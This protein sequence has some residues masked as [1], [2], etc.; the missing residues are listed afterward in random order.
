M[1]PA[2][3]C[4]A[5]RQLFGLSYCKAGQLQ[6]PCSRFK[7]DREPC[8]TNPRADT[9]Y[10]LFLAPSHKKERLR[11]LRSGGTLQLVRL[12]SPN[13]QTKPYPSCACAG[14]KIQLEEPLNL[15]T[16]QPAVVGVAI[17]RGHKRGTKFFHRRCH[18]LQGVRPNCVGRKKP[19][20]GFGVIAAFWLDH[21]TN[22]KNAE[23]AL[24][25]KP[26]KP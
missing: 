25:A 12:V 20:L 7:E 26:R 23:P 21:G 8:P 22:V 10:F 16:E 18:T 15:G 3:R 5:A 1:D 24:L 19:D 6:A 2:T 11:C 14:R 4:T 17:V 9:G 13:H